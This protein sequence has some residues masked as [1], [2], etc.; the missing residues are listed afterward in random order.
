MLVLAGA[1]WAAPD[2]VLRHARVW[3]GT[4]AAVVEDGWVA[5]T[6]DR[7][8]GV[9]PEPPPADVAGAPTLDVGGRTVLPGL[10]DAH[11]HP[12]AVPGA[13]LRGE[14][15]DT[16][17]AAR[18]RGLRSFVACGVTT[19]LDAGASLHAIETMRGWIAEGLPAPSL[20]VLGPVVGPSHGYVDAFLDGHPGVDTLEAAAAHLD[21]LEDI[22][23]VG[24]K[25]TIEP[26]YFL[27]VLPLHDDAFRRRFVALAAERGLPVFVHA[28]HRVAHGRALD[29]GAAAVLHMVRERPGD[30]VRRYAE[31][32]TPLVSTLD[33]ESALLVAWDDAALD[34]PLARLVV[35]PEQRETAT[36]ARGWRQ[37]KRAMAAVSI[38]GWPRWTQRTAGSLMPA[39][40]YLRVTERRVAR[41]TRALHAADATLVLGSD[42]GACD[43]YAALF[44]GWATLVELELLVAA[45]LSPEAALLAGTR[46]GARL[47][48]REGEV[49]VLAPG[50][51]ADLVVVDGDPLTDISA[52]RDVAWVM[53]AGELRTPRGWMEGPPVATR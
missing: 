5:V 22:G 27:P 10:V 15:E 30:L 12:W 13:D 8:V 28:Q 45:G 17:L 53:R 6:G 34:H 49:G 36:S 31:T 33:L 23:A 35:P 25:L 7:V 42:S 39:Y 16:R 48:G 9:G 14:D 41:T 11:T 29:A 21:T 24:A 3:D 32:G 44:H 1:A 40:D 47:L 19:V 46:E 52:R 38:P 50:A 37:S 20:H 51:V 43:A 4:G 2:V 18:Q 26:G